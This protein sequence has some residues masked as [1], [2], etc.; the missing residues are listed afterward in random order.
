MATNVTSGNA[1]SNNNNNFSGDDD[2]NDA[3]VATIHRLLQAPV[4]LPV[5]HVLENVLPVVLVTIAIVACF[6]L[7]AYPLVV[8]RFMPQNRDNAGNRR[9][10]AYQATNLCTNLC[11][12]LA[13]LYF[14]YVVLPQSLSNNNGNQ[15]NN[16]IIIVQDKIQGHDRLYVLGAAQIGFQIWSIFMGIWIV[17]ESTQMLIH[18]VAVIFASSKSVFL[19][20]GFR[21]F[22]PLG[23]G[24]TELSSVPLS[25]MNAFKNNATWRQQ[26][27]QYYLASRLIFSFMFLGIRIGL[28]VPQHMEYLRLSGWV[29]YLAG[30]YEALAGGYRAFMAVAWLGSAFLLTL[31]LLWGALIVKGVYNVIV[32]SSIVRGE[33]K[34]TLGKKTN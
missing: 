27:P 11:L 5:Q 16:D 6:Y 29:T 25:V 4:F 9:R 20:N 8:D 3:T 22:A 10:L 21:Y 18:H 7:A 24:M 31:Q 1:W 30:D 12:G 13:G 34:T 15:D 2:N 17:E 19:T 23:L 14:Q 32:P 28:F 26:W 33:K